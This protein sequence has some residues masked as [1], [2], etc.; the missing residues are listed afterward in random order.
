MATIQLK[1]MAALPP[2]L[3]DRAGR[4]AERFH[5]DAPSWHRGADQTPQLAGIAEAVRAQRNIRI[6]HLRW[7]LPQQLT[8]TVEP[9]GLVLKAGRWYLVVTTAGS[10]RTYRVAR[11]ADL[12]LLDATFERAPGFDLASCWH[13]H[14]RHFD[15]HRHVG[16]A[17]LRL[18]PG[19]FARLPE[20]AEPA[21][22]TAARRSVQ[23]DT[24]G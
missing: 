24:R 17:T 3:R 7:A 15:E 10:L 22:V 5:L 1:L 14:L 23:P 12:E 18:S 16:H 8:R 21:V 9:Y 13:D 2:E 6:S 19:A 20:I 4:I 11:I